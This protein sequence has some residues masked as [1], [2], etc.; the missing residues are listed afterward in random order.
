MST[1]ELGGGAVR[2][3]RFV[4]GFQHEVLWTRTRVRRAAGGD[5]TQVR[6]A[7][8][9][10]STRVGSCETQKYK[11]I[12]SKEAMHIQLPLQL[13]ANDDITLR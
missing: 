12:W 2:D 3:A 1:A 8:V 9:V 13:V 6:A 5:Q 7:T 4:V 11:I 10:T